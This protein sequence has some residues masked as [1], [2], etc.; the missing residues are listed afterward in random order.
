M[1]MLS[2]RLQVLLDEGRYRRLESE[3]R[4]RKVAVAA[5]VRD[6]I[7]L[8]YPVTSDR[9]RRAAGALLAAEPMDVPSVEGLRV[10]LDELRGRHDARP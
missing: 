9:R 3:A 10:E 7:D 2:R 6:A 5:L 1:C 4:R 8:A